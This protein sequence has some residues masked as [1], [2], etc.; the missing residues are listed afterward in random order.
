V[1]RTAMLAWSTATGLVIGL[2]AG[3]AVLAV[4]TIAANVVP[5]VPERLVD[6]LRVPALVILLGVV[7]LAAA[8][9]GFLEGRAKLP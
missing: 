1:T 8:I 5:G 9:V 6:R 4:L 2:L 3:V 7:P